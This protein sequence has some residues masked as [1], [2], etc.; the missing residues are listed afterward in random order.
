MVF[1]QEQYERR[2]VI[3]NGELTK[4]ICAVC[5]CEIVL[6]ANINMP[7]CCCGYRQWQREE[8]KLRP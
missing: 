6:D 4:E 7:F 2:I 8:E 1:T 3:T 5:R